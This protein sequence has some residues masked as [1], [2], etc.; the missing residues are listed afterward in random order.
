MQCDQFGIK[1]LDIRNGHSVY[2]RDLHFLAARKNGL[3]AVI[4]PLS[5]WMKLVVMTARA[6]HG[7]AHKDGAGQVGRIDEALA[8]QF[9]A[10]HI[11]LVQLRTQGVDAGSEPSL[12][13]LELFL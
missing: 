5:E 11:G 1:L 12:E 6:A 3:E 7:D 8:V 13:V 2:N 10:V 4:I 9:L